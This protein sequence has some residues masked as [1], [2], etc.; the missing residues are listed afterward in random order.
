VIA[1]D[2][3]LAVQGDKKVIAAYLGAEDAEAAN[4]EKATAP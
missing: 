2:T 3:P 1:D 4:S